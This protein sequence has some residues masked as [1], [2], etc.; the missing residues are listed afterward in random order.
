VDGLR[1]GRVARHIAAGAAALFVLYGGEP[2]AAAVPPKPA[3][4]TVTI[5]AS[6]FDPDSLTI[7]PGDTVVWVNHD[8]IA[9][10]ATAKAGGFDSRE[11]APGKSW[12]HKFARAGDV[13]YFCTYH[14]TMKG[15]VRVNP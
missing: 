8:L 11:I 14:P 12:T 7:R 9:H 3:T 15:A 1:A 6:R 10:T 4:H 2:G 13:A 5:D